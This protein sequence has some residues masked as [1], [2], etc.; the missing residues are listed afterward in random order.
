MVAHSLGLRKIIFSAD[1]P[2]ALFCKSTACHMRAASNSPNNT[3]D[4]VIFATFFS[5]EWLTKREAKMKKSEINGMT[6][7]LRRKTKIKP[8]KTKKCDLDSDVTSDVIYSMKNAFERS[9]A[10]GAKFDCGWWRG[11]CW[12][13]MLY[14]WFQFL[15]AYATRA[16]QPQRATAVYGWMNSNRQPNDLIWNGVPIEMR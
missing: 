3:E 9:L 15:F 14:E 8:M 11:G 6:W 7:F 13:N 12:N 16:L 5:P 4:C 1:L 2:S 10:N